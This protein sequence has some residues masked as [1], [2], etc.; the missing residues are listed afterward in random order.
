MRA[1]HERRKVNQ[2]FQKEK[3]QVFHVDERGEV[4]LKKKAATSGRRKMSPLITDS[5]GRRMTPSGLCFEVRFS[6]S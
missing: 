3:H 6:S 1:A 2:L 4:I 5:I